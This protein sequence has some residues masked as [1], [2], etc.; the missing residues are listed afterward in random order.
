MTRLIAIVIC[1]LISS[2]AFAQGTPYPSKPVRILIPSAPGGTPDLLGRMLAQ[3][4]SERLGQPFVAENRAG[5]NGN[6]AGELTAKAP[7][8]GHILFLATNGNLSINPA[9]YVKI[10]YDPLADFA[11]VSIAGS[12]GLYFLACPAHPANN[13]RELI[14]LA[15]QKPG[16]LSYASSGFGSNNHLAGEMLN[17]F[18]DVKITHIPYKA[19]AQGVPDTMSCKV[20]VSVGSVAGGLPFIRSGKLKALGITTA[21]RFPGTPDVAT[22]IEAGM[23]NFEAVAYYGIV[24]T[25]GTPRPVIDR[26]H[27]EMVLALKERDTA[28]KLLAQGLLVV[29]NTPEQFST[30]IRAEL[31]LYTKLAKALN[32]KI[33]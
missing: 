14:A 19:F 30:R 13:M 6:L 15:K 21:T 27:S 1:S 20:D 29:G 10:P 8:D 9:I 7:P 12:G 4:F 11:P 25:A 32:L 3:R 22:M 5:A 33:E 23:P 18:A 16:A 31:E 2:I 17:T 28:E 26:L 24:T